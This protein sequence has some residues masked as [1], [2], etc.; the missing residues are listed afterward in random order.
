MLTSAAR[1]VIRLVVLTVFVVVVFTLAQAVATPDA[2]G[3]TATCTDSDGGLN[4]EVAGY[5]V[6]VA[7]TGYTQTR[8]DVCETGD[9]EGYLRE[10]YCNGT[11]PWPQF[12]LCRAGCVDG[13]CIPVDCTDGDG[14][15]YAVEGGVCG[16]VDC[17]D[18]NPAVHPGT[19][20]ICTN[21]V[22]DDCDGLIDGEDGSCACTDSDGGLNYDV[23]GFVVGVSSTGRPVT[24]TDVCET[25]D[26]LREYFCKGLTPWPQFY[27]CRAGC[28]DGACIPVDCTDGDGDGYA[29][30]GGVCGEV[31][32]DDGNPAVHP[33]AAELCTNGV[34]DDCDGL[35]DG[36]DGSCTCTDSDGGLNYDVAGFVVGV[37]ST[38]LPVTRTDVCETGDTLREYF[39]K[40]LTPW[41]NFAACTYGCAAGACLG[42]ECTDLDAD[43]YALEGGD[44]GPV[45]C[46]DSAPDV[47]P[48][49]AEVCNNGIDDDC[50]SLVDGSDPACFPCTDSDGGLAYFR[51]G[52]VTELAGNSY[53]DACSETPGQ[54]TE[55][56]CDASFNA[57]SE[58]YTCPGSCVDGACYAPNIIVVGWDGTQRDHFFEC[59]NRELPECAAGLPNI[60]GLSNDTIYRS[61]TTNA[62]TSTKPGWAQLFSGYDAE[63]TGIWDLAIYQPIPEGYSVFEKIETH[64]GPENVVTMFISA[65]GDHTGDVCVGE[66]TYDRQG[67]LIIEELGQPWCYASDHI[68]YFEL[69]RLRNGDIGNRA[70]ELLEAHQHDLFFALFLFR[71]PDVTG[72][73]SGENSVEYS[74]RLLELDGWL[75]QIRAKVQALGISDKT[76]IY[77]VT[78]HGFDE[79]KTNHLNAPYGFFASNDPLVMRSGDRKDPAATW[80]DRYGIDPTIGGAPPLNAYSLYSLPPLACI[81]EGQA[82]LDYPGASTCCAGLQLISLDKRTGGCIPATGGTGDNSGYCTACGDGVCLAPE[83]PCNCPQDCP[84]Y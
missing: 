17:D 38:G 33:G 52:V 42:P 50:N 13:A 20:E 68:D 8:Y 45:D 37:G 1:E 46:D 53:S 80:L 74:R 30:E 67:N 18:S 78:D 10:Y 9:R 28:V 14:D 72:H 19:A 65:K 82:Y 75:G 35:V 41:P 60:A 16:E 32:C 23:A 40:G 31:D 66:V 11:T 6:G 70:L 5:V 43:G 4:Y 39:C 84:L 25:G 34:D 7:A 48:G 12:Y 58:V 15:G 47:H 61:T 2:Y 54:L 29:L 71:D 57:R 81:P 55:Y 3:Q 77:V 21:G 44:C 56:Y 49:A 51:Q 76:L 24:R 22:D 27:V 36:E 79:G 64:F 59:Y 62:S 69:N 63:V 73:L 83:G 26:T